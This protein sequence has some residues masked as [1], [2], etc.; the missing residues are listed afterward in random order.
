[1]NKFGNEIKAK[2]RLKP[3]YYKGQKHIPCTLEAPGK[4]PNPWP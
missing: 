4:V 2:E 1:M 3:I